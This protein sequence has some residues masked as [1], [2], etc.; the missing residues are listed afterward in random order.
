[1]ESLKEVVRDE[2]SP[3][4]FP[5]TH[6]FNTIYEI[7]IF[8]FHDTIRVQWH[9]MRKIDVLSAFPNQNNDI[10]VFAGN[11]DSAFLHQFI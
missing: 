6:L 2:G 7:S 10:L 4:R 9:K 1:M 8:K 5:G 3:L 11:G